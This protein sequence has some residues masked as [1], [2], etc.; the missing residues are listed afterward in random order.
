MLQYMH[1]DTVHRL[2]RYAVVAIVALVLIA[3]VI[4]SAAT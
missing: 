3:F 1:G 2:V 4:R